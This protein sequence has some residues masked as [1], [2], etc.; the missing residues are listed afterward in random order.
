VSSIYDGDPR[1]QWGS[2]TVFYL[3]DLDGSWTILFNR[4]SQR[5]DA[6]D[7]AGAIYE[8]ASYKTNFDE[9]IMEI[10]GAPLWSI[11]AAMVTWAAEHDLWLDA[12]VADT[13]SGPPDTG[14]LAGSAAIENLLDGEFFATQYSGQHV[15]GYVLTNRGRNL[16]DAL[17]GQAEIDVQRIVLAN[18]PQN[19]SLGSGEQE[20]AA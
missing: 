4:A 1:V 16:Y 6:Y 5:W 17:Y 2:D 9:S 18:V 15:D 12:G 8:P 10:I 13:D 14:T 19:H 20:A 3:P 11:E 7:G